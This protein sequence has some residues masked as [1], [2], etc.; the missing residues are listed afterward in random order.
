MKADKLKILILFENNIGPN[1]CLA[2]TKTTWT[3]I[4]KINLG[5]NIST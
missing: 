3:I 5:D 4:S 2:L 1:G